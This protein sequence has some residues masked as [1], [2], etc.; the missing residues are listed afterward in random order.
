MSVIKKA[1]DLFGKI[2]VYEP[3]GGGKQR[4]EIYIRLQQSVEGMEIGM[5][6]DG[7][8]SMLEQFAAHLPKAFRQPGS[9]IMEPVVRSLCRFACDYSGDGTILP[10]YWAV[11]AGGK[12]IEPMGKVSATASETLPVEGPKHWGG[13][14]FLLPALN[15]FLDEFA[16]SKWAVVLFTTDGV[17][18]DLE[19]VKNR[20]MEVGFEILEEK[21]GN[22]K[23]VMVG[24]THAGVSEKEKQAIKETL[25][26]LDDMFDDTELEDKGIDLWDCKLAEDM[27]EL[28]EIW[29]EVDFE[30]NI[31]GS[32]R[33]SDHLGNEVYS[34][35]DQF[36]QRIEFT[37]PE[38][39]P[40]VTVEI[41]GQ[42]ITQPLK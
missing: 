2:N 25:S 32:V 39:T 14:T 23:F 40:S 24:V 7:S 38:G 28:A 11:G 26:E 33:I 41:A 16:N 29:D 12:E 21:R 18:E 42:T 30:I 22:C 27:E 17:F 35:T 4:V 10:I 13:N 3:H 15:Y 5:A 37:V 6:I 20:V 36:P 1:S 8:R 34:K 9:N 19:A 31:P